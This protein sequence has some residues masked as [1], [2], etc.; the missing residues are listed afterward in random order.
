MIRRRASG[1]TWYVPF[2]FFQRGIPPPELSNKK[3]TGGA[4]QAR[5]SFHLVKRYIITTVHTAVVV[6]LTPP[7]IIRII[8][9]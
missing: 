4:D 6:A 9:L 1:S 3:K 2:T 7:L 8:I 5:Q